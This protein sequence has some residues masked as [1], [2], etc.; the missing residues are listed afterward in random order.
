MVTITIAHV[1]SIAIMKMLP[2]SQ[3]TEA[4][5]AAHAVQHVCRASCDA[6]TRKLQ[7]P[8]CEVKDKNAAIPLAFYV[9]ILLYSTK[10]LATQASQRNTVILI[11]IQKN[12]LA[13][14]KRLLIR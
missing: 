12:L 5:R 4:V 9:A 6:T 11:R 1:I 8:S 3:M 13:S 2:S 7:R 14:G 10:V